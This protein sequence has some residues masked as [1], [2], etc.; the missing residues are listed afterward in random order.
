MK[1]VG[2]NFFP[3]A[4]NTSASITRAP[5]KDH[6]TLV[7]RPQPMHERGATAWWPESLVKLLP[8]L[9][10]DLKD[11]NNDVVLLN[12]LRIIAMDKSYLNFDLD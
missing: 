3:H 7:K 6:F 4:K 8:P 1:I 9:N 12:K 5:K 10:I 2:A 11:I